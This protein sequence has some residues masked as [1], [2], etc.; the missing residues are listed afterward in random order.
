MSNMA[1]TGGKEGV[2]LLFLGRV[3]RYVVSLCPQA[4]FS[5]RCV[6]VCKHI[7]TNNQAQIPHRQ[8]LYEHPE[9]RMA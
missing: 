2:V 7:H 4:R 1:R 8:G 9:E 3:S 5:H 6:S